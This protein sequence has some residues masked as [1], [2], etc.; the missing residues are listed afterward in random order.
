MPPSTAPLPPSIEG[1]SLPTA[2]EDACPELSED[3]SLPAPE[4]RLH[5]AINVVSRHNAMEEF[6]SLSAEEL[7]LSEYLLDQML[8]LQDSLESCLV[9]R[10]IK[11]LLGTRLDAP[12]PLAKD[13]PSPPVVE[14]MVVKGCPAVVCAPCPPAASVEPIDLGVGPAVHPHRQ[15]RL[16]RRAC[17]GSM[18]PKLLKPHRHALYMKPS[19]QRLGH[20]WLCSL[21]PLC[22]GA[23]SPAA[24][25]QCFRVLCGLLRPA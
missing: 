2:F 10:V 17:R 24:P 11:E 8:L 19:R 9:P 13:I 20:R 23:S 15:A 4:I 25:G 14:G 6:R 12:P 16:T 1:D 5:I 18:C 7:S 22:G 3:D 21:C